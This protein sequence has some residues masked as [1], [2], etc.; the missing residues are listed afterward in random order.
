VALVPLVL[1]LLELERLVGLQLGAV[2]LA[3][4]L[5]RVEPPL[6][7]LATGALFLLAVAAADR[8]ARFWRVVDASGI[9]ID[10][11]VGY[12]VTM[13]FV[14]FSWPAAAAGFLLFRACDILKPWP[15]SA[16]DRVKSGLGVVLDDVAAGAWAGAGLWALLRWFPGVLG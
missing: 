10:E 9:V 13:A 16:F 5:S 15:A 8:A 2:P 14:P 11:V 3:W 1:L 4:A 6:A 7:W 12:L